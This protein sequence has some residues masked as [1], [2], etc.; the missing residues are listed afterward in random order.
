MHHIGSV[1][2]AF[3][4]VKTKKYTVRKVAHNTFQEI[5]FHPLNTDQ[6]MSG[7]YEKKFRQITD[8]EKYTIDKSSK[9]IHDK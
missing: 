8:K 1:Y 9:H 4:D 6:H 7:E 3:E 5:N 2:W